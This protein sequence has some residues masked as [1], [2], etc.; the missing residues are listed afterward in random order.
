[1]F[2]TPNPGCNSC[3]EQDALWSGCVPGTEPVGEVGG[4]YEYCSIAAV[5]RH[6]GWTLCTIQEP[7][8]KIQI[9]ICSGVSIKWSFIFELLEQFYDNIIYIVP[10]SNPFSSGCS[11]V[12]NIFNIFNLLL[13]GKWVN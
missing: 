2:V 8:K 13:W 3:S 6:T 9:N 1:M 11:R 12:Y 4:V 10:V 5:D 7:L